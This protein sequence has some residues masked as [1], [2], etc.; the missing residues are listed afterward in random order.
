MMMTAG[1]E[2]FL[3]C[4]ENG[5][6]QLK[7]AGL[8]E[9]R[10]VFSSS[11]DVSHGLEQYVLGPAIMPSPAI[12][13]RQSTLFLQPAGNT[14]QAWS[15]LAAGSVVKFRARIKELV[16]VEQQAAGLVGGSFLNW[17]AWVSADGAI[18]LPK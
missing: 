12:N 5:L 2:K 11:G 3:D 14:T 16:P 13:R 8:T 15:G 6:E 10:I 18:P 1:V 17:S 7:E 9:M 4:P